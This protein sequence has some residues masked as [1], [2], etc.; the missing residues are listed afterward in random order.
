M[1]NLNTHGLARCPKSSPQK[2]PRLYGIA[3]KFIYTPKHV[4]WLNMAEIEPNVLIKQ[5][6]NR[7]IDNI[8]GMQ[9]EVAAWQQRRDK[10]TQPSIRASSPPMPVSNLSAYIRHFR[11]DMTLGYEVLLANF[12]N[13]ELLIVNSVSSRQRNRHGF[14]VFGNLCFICRDFSI[15]VVRSLERVWIE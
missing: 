6:L 9:R 4:S 8:S 5:Y 12:S 2:M 11:R 10:K 1:D 13:V 14:P 7:R 15:S 3:S